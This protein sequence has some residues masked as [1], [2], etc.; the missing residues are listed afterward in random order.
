MTAICSTY[1]LLAPEGFK[2]STGVAYPAGALIAAAF[3]VI[4]LAKFAGKPRHGSI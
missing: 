2:L 3:L 4:F 1:I